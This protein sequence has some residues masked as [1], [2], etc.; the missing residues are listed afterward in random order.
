MASSAEARGRPRDSWGLAGRILRGSVQTLWPRQRLLWTREGLIYFIFGLALLLT[1]LVQQINLILLVSTFAAGPVVSSIFVSAAMLRRL[2]VA[3]KSPRYTFANDPIEIDYSLENARRLSAALALVVEDSLIPIERTFPGAASITPQVFFARVPARSTSN[4]RWEGVS[5]GRGRYRF[6]DLSLVTRSPFG[7][8]E[9]RVSIPSSGELVVYPTIGQLTRRWKVLQR[10]ATENRPGQRHDRSA[11]QEEYHGLRDYRSG[12]SPRWIHW[13]T[14]AR[15]GELMVKEFE[16]QHEQDL[17]I[18]IDP[19]LPRTKGQVEQRE[20]LEMAIRFAATLCLETCR[21]H[22]RRLLLAWTGPTPG[23]RQGPSS[24]KLAHDLLEQLAIMRPTNEGSLA[25]LFDA[26]PPTILRDAMLVVISTRPVNLIEEAERSTSLSATTAR[27]LMNRALLLNTAAGDLNELIRFREASARN[28]LEQKLGADIEGP[29]E[30]PT[31]LVT[32][33][34]DTLPSNR[35]VEAEMTLSGKG[36]GG[37]VNSSRI[38]S[39]GL[40]SSE[41]GKGQP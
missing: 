35:S 31:E 11:Q 17:A 20:A 28:L 10:Q 21:H 26:L 19:W 36:V 39:E 4:I 3:R 15:L 33:F 41:N 38:F 22:G 30:D 37:Q 1:G 9:R 23:I 7:L 27:G 6:G 2:K 13:R 32:G 18:L 8:L 5:P 40:D 24:V 29:T 12:D 16:Q 14:S 34:G 25:E